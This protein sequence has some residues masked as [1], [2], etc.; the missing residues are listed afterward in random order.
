MGTWVNSLQ[1]LQKRIDAI[2]IDKFYG[3]HFD[4]VHLQK[5]IE[6]ILEKPKRYIILFG[7]KIISF[8]FIDINSS[9]QDYYK[10]LHYLP[11]LLLAITS[12]VG[13]I[14]S[15]KKS[16]KLNYLILIYFINI[17]I[18][19]CFFILPRYKLFIFPFQ[20]IFTNVLIEYMSKRY[21]RR[22]D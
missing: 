16:N 15:D 13:I 19:S 8:L 1:V 21:F 2:P 18:F 7:K 4:N 10:S 20:I 5:A 14:L 22:N 17:I 9:R 12:L 11:V 6:N 3:I